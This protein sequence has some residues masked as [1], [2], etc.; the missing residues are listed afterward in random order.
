MTGIATIVNIV[1]GQGYW[2][3]GIDRWHVVVELAV[4]L[5]PPSCTLFLIQHT[6]L[7]SFHDRLNR[8]NIGP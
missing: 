5:M 4:S 6:A 3:V 8:V 7:P 2:H 1:K